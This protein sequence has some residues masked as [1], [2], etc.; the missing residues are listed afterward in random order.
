M[1][2]LVNFFQTTSKDFP[3]FVRLMN[4]RTSSQVLE[5]ASH[6]HLIKI[7]TNVESPTDG[8][9]ILDC[10]DQIQLKEIEGQ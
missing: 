10:P 6:L 8:E 9:S 4:G 1:V 2:S 7:G 3:L 5:R